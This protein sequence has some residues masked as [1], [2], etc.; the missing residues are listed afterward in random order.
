MAPAS[1]G[2]ARIRRMVT[3][4]SGLEY[5]LFLRASKPDALTL[6]AAAPPYQVVPIKRKNFADSELM[7]NLRFLLPHLLLKVHQFYAS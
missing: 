7:S 3:Q 5:R 1:M 6:S 2:S 4:F